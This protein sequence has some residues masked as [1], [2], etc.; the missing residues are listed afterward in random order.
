MSKSKS[1]KSSKINQLL[2]ESS[3]EKDIKMEE[4]SSNQDIKPK[5]TKKSSKKSIEVEETVLV[6]DSDKSFIESLGVPENIIKHIEEV[7]SEDESKGANATQ[8]IQRKKT[9][10]TKNI[11]LK[12]LD[13]VN[14]KLDKLIKKI[15]FDNENIDEEDKEDI[16]KS[17]DEILQ[18]QQILLKKYNAFISG[19]ELKP[20]E[21]EINDCK[22][23]KQQRKKQAVKEVVLDEEGNPVK[24]D[25]S[26]SHIYTKKV[27]Y[28]AVFDFMEVPHDTL[29]SVIDVQEKLRKFIKNEKDIGNENNVTGKLKSLLEAIISEKVK[30]DDSVSS[31][32]PTKINNSGDIFKYSAYCFPKALSKKKD[33]K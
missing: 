30:H 21:L 24:K 2:E 5:K 29:I 10:T 32:I 20:E 14:S 15:I 9:L 3:S 33:L 4:L 22:K 27:P 19:K 1:S 8:T 11:I 18:R 7:E 6:S 17:I 25:T 26:K 28:D 12:E 31:E 16:A 23:T 13:A